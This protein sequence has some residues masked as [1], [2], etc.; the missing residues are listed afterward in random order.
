MEQKA[1]NLICY[2]P[3]KCCSLETGVGYFRTVISV[4]ATYCVD[5]Q[6]EYF[7]CLITA[8]DHSPRNAA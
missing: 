1:S 7:R 6:N 2:G 8:A 5:A 4:A 3:V